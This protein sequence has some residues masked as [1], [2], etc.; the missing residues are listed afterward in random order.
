MMLIGMRVEPPEIGSV[1]RHENKIVLAGVPQNIPI[2]PHRL[3]NVR[4]VM[5]LV[6][7]IGC[8]TYEFNAETLVDQEPHGG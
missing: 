6:P 8:D 4:N 7:R 1:V 5:R 2:L 3:V